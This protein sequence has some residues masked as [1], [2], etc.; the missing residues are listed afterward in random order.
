MSAPSNIKSPLSYS[1]NMMRELLCVVTGDK[2]HPD[3]IQHIQ[4]IFNLF[5]SSQTYRAL[6]SKNYPC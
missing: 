5:V 3:Q 1:E 6:Y 2:F 4:Y